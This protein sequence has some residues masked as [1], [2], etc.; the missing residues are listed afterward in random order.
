MAITLRLASSKSKSGLPSAATPLS[1]KSRLAKTSSLTGQ[2]APRHDLI[3]SV[4]R[5]I[6]RIV[7]CYYEAHSCPVS[8][9]DV[10]QGL[11]YS[12][13]IIL[14]GPMASLYVPFCCLIA[15]QLNCLIDTAQPSGLILLCSHSSC[16]MGTIITS[17]SLLFYFDMQCGADERFCL[18]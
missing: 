18:A 13:H 10:E 3:S 4:G 17:E 9:Y 14:C 1:V 11:R 5:R 7:L 8:C 12:G 15:I 16:S 2:P 6:V